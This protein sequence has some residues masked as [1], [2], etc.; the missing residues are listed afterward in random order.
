MVGDLEEID[1]RQPLRDDRRVDA[2]LDVAHEQEPP[3]ADL[4][5]E[6]DRHVID[7]RA[8]VRRLDGHGSAVRPEHAHRDVVDREAIPGR[9]ATVRRSGLDREPSRPRVV[10]RSRA[11]HPGFEHPTDAVPLEQQREP[12]DVILVRVAED[13]DVDPSIPGRHALVERHEE[14]VGIGAAVDQQPPAARAFDE[15]GVTLPDVEDRDPAYGGGP[16]GDDP[17]AHQHRDREAGEAGAT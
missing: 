9:Q 13:H 16:G 10:A 14:T 17:A 11:A 7:R 15:D 4:A 5:E 12:G 6:H 8:T 1:P 3:R 2:L